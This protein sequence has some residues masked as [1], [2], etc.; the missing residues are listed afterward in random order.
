MVRICLV[1]IV[2]LLVESRI[3]AWYASYQKMLDAPRQF[4][5]VQRILAE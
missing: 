1:I 5:R 3:P 4:E 2:C